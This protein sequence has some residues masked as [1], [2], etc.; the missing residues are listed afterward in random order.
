M[1]QFAQATLV[2]AGLWDIAMRLRGQQGTDGVMPEV[3]PEGSLFV[4]VDG[5]PGQVDLGPATR[6][7]A[8]PL[9]RRIGPAQ[10]R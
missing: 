7:L 4:L 3:W 2:G 5:A 6:G 1:I 8:S 10:R 9:P